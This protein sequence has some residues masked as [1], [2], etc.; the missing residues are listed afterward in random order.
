MAKPS[1]FFEP[2]TIA[3]APCS[4]MLACR[5]SI[6]PRPSPRRPTSLTGALPLLFRTTS[7]M[8]CYIASHPTTLTFAFS[9]VCAI[10]TWLT[11][12]AKHKLA[13]RS[14]A[15]VFLGYPSTFLQLPWCYFVTSQSVR[16]QRPSSSAPLGFLNY[17]MGN[18]KVYYYQED[19]FFIFEFMMWSV[20]T[21]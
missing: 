13:P 14:T 20:L 10:P 12:T 5:P 21:A 6:G 15:C 2:S 7:L 11:A 16:S 9:A 3:F 17:I 18:Y 4:F 1:A 8:S 19:M